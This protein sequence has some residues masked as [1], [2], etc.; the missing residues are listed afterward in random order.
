MPWKVCTDIKELKPGMVIRSANRQ[1][2]YM[3]TSNFGDRATAVRT[4][5]VTNPSEWHIHTGPER[6]DA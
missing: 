6:H 1:T 5:D 4:V 3:V 2:H